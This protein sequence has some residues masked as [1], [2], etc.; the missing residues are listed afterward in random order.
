MFEESDKNGGSVEVTI[1]NTIH[2]HFPL[3]KIIDFDLTKHPKPQ[4]KTANKY[5][6]IMKDG[7]AKK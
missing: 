5:I 3:E 4:W 6:D 2:F 1:G 7:Q